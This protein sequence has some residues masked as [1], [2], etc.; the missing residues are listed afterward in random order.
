MRRTG[1]FMLAVFLLCSVSWALISIDEAAQRIMQF[2]GNLTLPLIYVGLD[3]NLSWEETGGD[4][5]G[6]PWP[7]YYFEATIN[8]VRPGARAYIVDP[9]TGQV[10]RW[11]NREKRGEAMRNGEIGGKSPDAMISPQQAFASAVNFLQAHNPGFNPNDYG[12]I[13][14]TKTRLSSTGGMSGGFVPYNPNL[15]WEVYQPFMG[16]YFGKVLTDA[17]GDQLYHTGNW[18]WVELDSESGDV[19]EYKGMSFP[20][21]VSL[22]PEISRP[23]AEQIA[24]GVFNS[25]PF[26]PFVSY[27]EVVSAEKGLMWK[28]VP[29]D[30]FAFVW[31]ID[32][33]TYSDNP[34]YQQE[35][36]SP[37]DR[38]GWEVIVDAH[39]GEVYKVNSY[40]G[41]CEGGGPP[42][43][44]KM[45]RFKKAPKVNM[46][47]STLKDGEPFISPTMLKGKPFL[48]ANE[49]WALAVVVEDKGKNIV[50]RYEKKVATIDSSKVVRK[51]KDLYVPLE[52]I[53]KIAGYKMKYIPKER[54]IYLERVQKPSGKE[55]LS[56]PAKVG[57]L[58][59]PAIAYLVWKAL[60]V[61]A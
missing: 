34:A 26:Y 55:N 6:L 40:L 22:V 4:G 29:P 39:T 57:L 54:K 21:N 46:P 3:H 8:D 44:E 16:L 13:G 14:I 23:Q 17:E 24:S 7:C 47:V 18:Y 32:V 15:S 11:V 60:R 61:L 19:Y 33:N 20:L 9:Y 28:S 53:A 45:E 48:K 59:S 37:E 43:K 58:S 49:A 50:L 35:V 31:A 27:A 5:P 38:Y 1:L 25:P 41:A 42:T 56:A 2:E 30:C 36:G 51:G 10:V 52:S 12:E